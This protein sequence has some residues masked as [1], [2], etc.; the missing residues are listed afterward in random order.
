MAGADPPGVAATINVIVLSDDPP[1]V[2]LSLLSPGETGA[3]EIVFEAAFTEPVSPTFNASSLVLEGL[4]GV[5]TVEGADP[6]YTVRVALDNPDTDGSLAIRLPAGAV[7]DPVGN[8]CAGGVSPGC[9]VR[10]WRGFLEEPGDVRTYAGEP[11]SLRAVPDC[12]AASLSLQ[13]RRDT[14]TKA[15]EDGPAA[16]TWDF[17]AVSVA[18]SGEYWCAA[19]YDGNTYLTR[20][21]RIAVAEHLA[22][23]RQPEDTLA[24]QGGTCAFS[25]EVAGGHPPL[26]YQW[27]KD[28]ANIPGGESPVL[29]LDALSMEQDGWYSIEV[30]D[31]H[32]DVVV[33][34]DARLTLASGLPGT[35]LGGLV[36]L[37]AVVALMGALAQRRK[38]A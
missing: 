23:T 31:S 37:A 16:Q 17:P 24:Q 30:W 5:V 9:L 14:A 15:P 19:S 35:G 6:V 2:I 28:G 7:M 12:A 25:V 3:D 36:V 32:T 34:R 8:V 29:S 11:L 20:R 21:A 13:W 27:K 18:D 38:P 1:G 22:I 4:S 33:S 26:S 10:N